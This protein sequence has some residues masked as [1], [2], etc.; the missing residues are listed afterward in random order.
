MAQASFSALQRAEIAEIA[1]PENARR[2]PLLSFS[3]LQRA[4]IAEIIAVTLQY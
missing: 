2:T 4:E 1:T 3:A